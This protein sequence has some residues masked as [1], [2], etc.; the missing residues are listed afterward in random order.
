MKKLILIT[1]TIILAGQACLIAQKLDMERLKGYK[2]RSIGPAGMSGRI[3]SIAAVNS[4]PEIIYAGAASGGL[5]KSTSGGINWEPI[6][7]KEAVLSIGAIAV[8][9]NNPS[10]IWVG[11]GEGNPRNSLNGGY[12]IYKSLDGGKNWK[13]M[14]LEKT[15]N[16]Y[17]IIIDPNNTNTVYVASIGSPW[18]EHPERGVYKTTDGGETWNKV[19][20]VD[21]KTGCADLVMDPRNPNKLIAA[22]WQHRRWPWTFKSGGPGSGLYITFD[23]GKTW[24]KR[25]S[26]DGLPEGELGRIGVDIAASKPELVYA[27]IESKKNGLYR[28]ADGGFK[29]ELVNGNMEEIGDRPFYYSEIHV[30]PKNENRLYTV[31][32]EVNSSID[33]GKSFQ[34]L[35]PYSGVHPDH[36]AWWIDPNNPAHMIDGNDGGLN[37]THD[38][39]KNWMFVDNIPV[40]QFYHVNVDMDQPYNVYG[41]LQDNGSWVGPAYT[42]K[43]GGIRNMYWQTVLFGDGFDTAPDPDDSRYGYAMSQ[44][45]ALSRFDRKTGFAKTIRP[46]YPDTKVRL[47]F[48]WNAGFAQDPKE[49]GTIYY[50][51]Q[52]L[53]KSTDKGSTWEIISPDLTTNDPEKQKSHESGGLTI[54]ASGA[55]NHCTILSIA[56]SAVEKGVIW[57]G[58][59]DGQVQL[60]RDGGKSWTNVTP[61]ITGMPKGAWIPQ[62]RASEYKAGE[63]F[64]VVNNYRQFDYKPYLFRSRDFGQT[65]ESIAT[66]AEFGDNNYTLCVQQDP[67][68]PKLIFV[69]AENGLFVSLDEG[70]TYTRWTAGFP[71]GVPV[72]DLVI[73]PR[74]YDLVIGTFGRAIYVLDDV[75]PLREM[76]KTGPQVLASSMHVFDAPD[77]YQVNFQDPT[78]ILFPGNSMFEGENRPSGA[79]I[80]YVLNKPEKKEE[81]KKEEVK[82][83]DKT[84]KGTAGK[85]PV[86]TPAAENKD[87]KK[88][89]KPKADS[90]TMEVFNAKNE[91]IRTIKQKVSDD[92]GFHRIFWAMNEKGERNPSRGGRRG[93][94]AGQG[95]PAGPQVLPGTYKVRITFDGKKDS[96][97][98]VVKSDPRFPNMDNV[99]QARYVLLKDLEKMTGLASK[100]MERLKESIEIADEYEKRIKESKRTDL[101]DATDKTKAIKDSLNAVIDF[102]IGKEDKR[103]GFAGNPVPTPVSYINTAQYYISTSK[104]PV[105]ATDER[106]M[107]QAS[108][109]V[110][111]ILDRVNKFYEKQWPEYRAAMEKVSINPFKT[112]EPLKR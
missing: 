38:Y 5:W 44:G 18:G 95:E 2:P 58:T 111:R 9:Q 67:V 40:G 100:S 107:K 48:N 50:G 7:D 37:I 112:Y 108:D 31:Y 94:G 41:G 24:T 83:D 42:W 1:I 52:F 84:K 33:G 105:N 78:G 88:D 45:G 28:S 56:P 22:M 91:K 61:K 106:V 19:L 102:M 77:A 92:N 51:S 82:A 3:T 80:S 104:D 10:V 36:H 76:V 13:L 96:T 79:M 89:E 86:T 63:V 16:I 98:V 30:D 6:F 71:A 57:V 72:M 27:L 54:D 90:L 64:V 75:R 68:E 4:N 26:K 97:M 85:T 20:F 15:R 74:E 11:T 43:D 35:L 66:S 99:L 17:K 53:H 21:E 12:G 32:S 101:K 110:D 81:P 73:H 109:A 23:G 29:W 39:G 70:K 69:G 62:I 93:G 34:K 87:D 65:W 59:D 47:R 49:H 25:T 46:T 55:E 103:Q 14:G 60:T 8:Q